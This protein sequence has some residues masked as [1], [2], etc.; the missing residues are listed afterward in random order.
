MVLSA[1][2]HVF[3]APPGFAL[4]FP[5]VTLEAET[6]HGFLQLAARVA[7]GS[8]ATYWRLKVCKGGTV[9]SLRISVRAKETLAGHRGSRN[10]RAN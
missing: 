7:N 9:T 8:L 10:T 3:N 1:T 6:T 4:P 5:K 2:P